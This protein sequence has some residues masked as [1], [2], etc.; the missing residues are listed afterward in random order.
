MITIIIIFFFNVPPEGKPINEKDC[1]SNW[2]FKKFFAPT[3]LG[4][5]RRAIV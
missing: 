3:S 1:T 2:W 5:L 4:L